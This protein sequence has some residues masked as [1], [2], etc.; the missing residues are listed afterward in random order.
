M[1]CT[2]PAACLPP[3][4]VLLFFKGEG[5][6]GPTGPMGPT[7]PSGGPPG[8]TGPSGPQ[9]PDGPSGPTGPSG[10]Q[11]PTGPSGA[12]GINGATGATGAIGNP[13]PTGA[14]GPTGA[15]GSAG[16]QGPPG[17]TGPQGA[18]GAAGPSGAT[19]PTGPVAVYPV[20]IVTG[21]TELSDANSIVVVNN[22]VPVT[23][24]LPAAVSS[25]NKSY[26]V[27]AIGIPVVTVETVD[28]SKIFTNAPVDS[29]NLATGDA[30]TVVSDGTRWVVI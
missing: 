21:N 7:G 14:T 24:T 4:P 17:A 25:L 23:I 11:G 12:Q 16:L 10:P 30:M 29:V 8:P 20:N 2:P 1:S 5:T 6:P 22:T 27:K 15:P 18:T 9:G 28:A 26:T 3:Q 19:G 13:G